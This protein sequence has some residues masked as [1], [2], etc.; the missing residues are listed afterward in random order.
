[1]YVLYLLLA[2]LILL[3]M[4]TIHEFGH[5]LAGKILNFK[6]NEFSI[7]FGKSLY[8][9]T[10]KKTGEVFSIRLIPL[11]GYC[12]FEGE[13]AGTDVPG[14]FNKMAP[15]KRLIVLF[16]GPFFNIL[17]AVLFSIIS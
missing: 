17:S 8:S 15:W 6:I 3:V 13:E 5:Y 9:H 7:G 1:M 12:A 14:A 11:G 16:C 4:V 10:S 2:L